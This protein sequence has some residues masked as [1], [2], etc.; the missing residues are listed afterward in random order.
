MG[1]KCA[2]CKRVFS[3]RTGTIME[4]SNIS[5][6][7]WLLAMHLIVTDKAGV[8]SVELGSRLGISQGMAW[9]LA[10]RIREMFA[11]EGHNV[12]RGGGS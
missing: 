10:A 8:T 4:R 1:F 6:Y 11:E 12:I 7:N 5:L 9:F 3:V 2:G